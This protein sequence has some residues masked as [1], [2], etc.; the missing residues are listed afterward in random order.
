MRLLFLC[1]CAWPALAGEYAIL[2]NGFRV[3]ADRHEERGDVVRLESLAGITEL[4]ADSIVGYETE[5]YVAPILP[6]LVAAELVTSPVAIAAKPIRSTREWVEEAALRAELPPAI[7]HA[8]AKAESGYR[9]DAISP[10]GAIGV[11][12]LMPGTA[13]ELQ[14]DPHDAEQNTQAGAMYLRGLLVRYNGDVARAL[15]AYNAGPGAVDKYGTVPPYRETRSYV[16]RVIDN[17][18]KL[19]GQ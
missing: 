17:Y 8:V 7:V 14:A 1:L 10:K 2:S 13:K 18:K 4:P 5:E 6:K 9:Q 16:N 11:M 12:Q 3:H 15:A 19:G